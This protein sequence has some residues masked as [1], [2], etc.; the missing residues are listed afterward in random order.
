MKVYRAKTK[1]TVQAK[2]SLFSIARLYNVSVED[3]DKANTEIIK[4]GL[5]VGQEINVPNKKKTNPESLYILANLG[6]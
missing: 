1:H 6:N 3:L 2:E 4:N 5:Q